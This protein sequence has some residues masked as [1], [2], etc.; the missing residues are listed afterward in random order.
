MPVSNWKSLFVTHETK[1][2]F[3]SHTHSI[4]TTTSGVL[5]YL[6]RNYF[7][8]GQISP[9]PFDFGAKLK[10]S[11]AFRGAFYFLHYLNFKPKVLCEKCFWSYTIFHQ[12]FRHFTM[13]H[14]PDA[15]PY[16]RHWLR[17]TIIHSIRCFVM[18]TNLGLAYSLVLWLLFILILFLL[19]LNT[20]AS[21]F[22]SIVK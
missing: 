1:F 9:N 8:Y 22:L 15:P 4:I 3:M 21:Q 11:E 13:G 12:T 5:A 2:S 18:L 14:G 17:P 19:Q 7:C 20:L 10:C 16:I 6:Y